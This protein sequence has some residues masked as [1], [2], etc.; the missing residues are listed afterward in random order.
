V[1]AERATHDV[2]STTDDD[3]LAQ[4][5]GLSGVCAVDVVIGVAKPMHKQRHMRIAMNKTMFVNT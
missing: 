5:V 3:L 4:I 1:R 2:P